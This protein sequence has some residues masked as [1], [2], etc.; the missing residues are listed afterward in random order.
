MPPTKVTA[1]RK[2]GTSYNLNLK[3]ESLRSLCESERKK[4]MTEATGRLQQ[5]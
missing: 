2:E 1:G 3:A 4:I 5:F